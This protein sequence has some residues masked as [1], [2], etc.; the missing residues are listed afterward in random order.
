[1]RRSSLLL[2][3]SSLLAPLVAHA[4][5][6]ASLDST[7]AVQSGTALYVDIVDSSVE[8]ISWDGIGVVDVT[9]PDGTY[10]TTLSP[11][12][13]TG[14]LCE[15]GNGPY[16]LTLG[17]DQAVF[18][19]WDVE[20]VD[21]VDP[22]GRLYSYDWQFNTGDFSIDR[23]VDASFYALVPGGATD[24]DA[25]VELQLDGVSGYVFDVSANATGV[26]GPLGGRSVEQSGNSTTPLYPLYLQPPS[27]A[28]YHTVAPD[29]FEASFVG[30]TSQDVS[31]A[32]MEP[33]T[34]FV[35]GGSSGTF[36]FTTTTEGSY[37]IQCDL[38]GNGTFDV[39]SGADLLL[40]GAAQPGL[41]S[42]EW[43]GMHAGVPVPLG[44]YD[45]RVD[46]LVG[47]F[48]YVGR[49][50]ETAY[51]GIR[52]FEVHHDGTRTPLSMYWNDGI[53]QPNAIAMSNGQVG[54]EN[55]GSTGVFSGTYGT[56]TEPNVNARSW[57]A[58]AEAGKGNEADLDTYTWLGQTSSSTISIESVDP[59][60]DSDGDGAGDFAESCSHGSDPLDP[61]TDDDG[62]EDGPQYGVDASS[63]GGG[64]LESNG[65]LA[66]RLARR[67]VQRSRMSM[68][69]EPRAAVSAVLLDLAPASGTLGTSIVEVSP[70]DL[71]DLTNATD[72]YS[73][74]YL[75]A[76]G[77][78]V[79]SVMLIET[80]GSVYE[81]SKLICDRA[82][83]ARLDDLSL[84]RLGNHSIIA[85]TATNAAHGSVDHMTTFSVHE[86]MQGGSGSL[87]SYWMKSHY[88][89]PEPGQRIVRVQTW[90]KE[91]GGETVL[92]NAV[93]DAA[94]ARYGRL[95]APGDE[96]MLSDEQVDA[97]VTA[98]RTTRDLS[99]PAVVMLAGEVV[100]GH[101]EVELRRL[102]GQGELSLRIV[103][104]EENGVDE[105]TTE[106]EIEPD[107][108]LD[109]I[110]L[111]VGFALDV[112]IEL[113]H[114]GQVEDQLWLSDGA[115]A[116]YDDA[117]W[118]GT[119][120]AT[121]SRSECITRHAQ[122]VYGESRVEFAGCAA[123]TAQVDDAAGFAGVARHLADPMALDAYRAL[124]LYVRSPQA[125]SLCLFDAQGADYCT[126]LEAA[127]GG[128]WFHVPLSAL[129][130]E[131]QGAPSS[132]ANVGLVT[133]SVHRP[134]AVA[135]DVTGLTFTNDEPE[136]VPASQE[137]SG[138]AVAPGGREHALWLAVLL[139][140]AGLRRRHG[141][142][143]EP[144]AG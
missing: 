100:G 54:Q 59:A 45:C 91:P 110:Q 102:H 76:A 2:A 16:Q 58:W 103:S 43:D 98:E 75:D 99:L 5:G 35:P 79:G 80:Q 8:T 134:G 9:A 135:M 48:H 1:M 108:E 50:I 105:V 47:E 88:P 39:S 15:W 129:V 144:D 27:I 81:H 139:L 3:L 68:S 138:C 18:T 112:T 46:V 29:V 115:W 38:D 23:A 130:T 142:R 78:R 128:R 118:G 73:L 132:P 25:V 85:A 17:S 113:L 90:S 31:G 114:D 121:F 30:G 77:E 42:V 33:C 104:L 13:N 70:T 127:P 60:V 4:E 51:P 136:V 111:D 6:T 89:E 22:G 122:E 65:R 14:H 83:G 131:V 53:V 44:T 137:Q 107:A 84:R 93:I 123:V 95:H 28:T 10:V 57:G 119:T 109:S 11:G 94:T 101:L 37:H 140:G 133:T 106:I 41:N 124:R 56:P 12:Q 52:M 66:S 40:T 67:A 61:D 20:V 19:E 21:A 74:D 36:Q 49:D 64:G 125:S 92:A 69:P 7:Q 86:D 72:V 96:A 34:Q 24:T 62:V 141:G 126:A 120:D 87:F 143:G 82:G 71:M 117:L 116:S 97:G 26:D 63:G 55:S 32:A